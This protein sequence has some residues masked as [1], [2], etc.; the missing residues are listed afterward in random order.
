VKGKLVIVAWKKVV[1]MFESRYHNIT[2]FL[3]FK[4]ENQYKKILFKLMQQIF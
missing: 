4:A 3:Y 1:V 2:T